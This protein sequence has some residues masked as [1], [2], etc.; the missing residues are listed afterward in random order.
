MEPAAA[1]EEEE[2]KPKRLVIPKS[3]GKLFFRRCGCIR[4]ESAILEPLNDICR[5]TVAEIINIAARMA[6]CEGK[7]TIKPRHVSGA[8]EQCGIYIY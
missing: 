7:S 6:V 4:I 2:E 3:V 5:E 1:V 8:M